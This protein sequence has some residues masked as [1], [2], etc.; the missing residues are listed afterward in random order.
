MFLEK[1]FQL[2]T[3]N[4]SFLSA[5]IGGQLLSLSGA[6]L[7]RDD[8]FNNNNTIKASSVIET[9]DKTGLVRPKPGTQMV[10]ADGTAMAVP[11]DSFVHPQTGR[12][13]PIQGNV[14]FDP[15]S[16]RLVFVVDS[17]TGIHYD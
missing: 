11:R 3:K 4:L 6:A 8:L 14:A 2:H 10:L 17:A 7:T 9:S 15:V 12:V 1:Y 5:G 16:Q 13:L